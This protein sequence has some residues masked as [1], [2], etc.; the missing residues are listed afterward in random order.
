MQLE[1][2][3]YE[4]ATNVEPSLRL[5]E[6]ESDELLRALAEA[7]DELDIRTDKDAKI[8]GK[9]E[10]QDAHLQDM[11]RLVVKEKHGR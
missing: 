11:R 3:Q 4:V 8:Q 9:L 6:R 2:E 5:F 7:L 10:A 1:F